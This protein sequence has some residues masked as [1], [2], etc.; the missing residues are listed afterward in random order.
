MSNR[1]DLYNALQQGC[2]TPFPCDSAQ[3]GRVSND[4]VN[5]GAAD[6]SVNTRTVAGALFAMVA[7]LFTTL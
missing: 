7:G 3:A 4:I 1:T 2:G 5:E 6:L